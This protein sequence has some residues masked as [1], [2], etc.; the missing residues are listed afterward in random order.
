ML[1]RALFSLFA[2]F[3]LALADPVF[4]DSPALTTIWEA[5]STGST[6]RLIDI[7]IQNHDYAHHRAG[8]GRGPLFWAYEFKNVDSLALLMH[9]G[10]EMTMEDLDGKEASTF[11]PG[12]EASRK[13]FEAD[14]KSK[15]GELATL[16]QEREEEFYS[17]KGEEEVRARARPP[18]PPAAPPAD[19]PA[20]PPPSPPP[21][22]AAAAAARRRRTTR[23]R[24]TTTPASTRSTMPTTRRTRSTRRRTTKTSR[25]PLEKIPYCSLAMVR[26]S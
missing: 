1:R 25:E 10:V 16:L 21:L 9:L 8:D 2:L 19:P 15:M 11:F 6:D 18:G 12:D 22:H 20:R 17:F 3:A 14:A 23:T 5:S 26:T 4:E 7:L 13:E 24:S